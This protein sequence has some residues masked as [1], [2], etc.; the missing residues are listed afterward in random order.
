MSEDLWIAAIAAGAALLGG[1]IGSLAGLWLGR[2]ERRHQRT[3]YLLEKKHEVY[4]EALALF[5]EPIKEYGDGKPVTADRLSDLYTMS[6]RVRMYA[7]RPIERAVEAYMKAYSAHTKN[8]NSK[9]EARLFT[10]LAASHAE[11]T[12]RMKHELQAT[13]PSLVVRLYYL[14]HNRWK[15]KKLGLS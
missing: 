13:K 9:E 14:F 11:L 1:A 7:T 10:D 6:T 12:G 5:I 2:Q 8:T 15:R 3:M 4:S